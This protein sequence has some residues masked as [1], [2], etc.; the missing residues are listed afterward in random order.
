MIDVNAPDGMF[1]AAVEAIKAINL[2]DNYIFRAEYLNRPKHNVL[3]YQRIPHNTV[4]VYDIEKGDGT[5][6]Y[7]PV[8]RVQ[9]VADMYGFETVPT[10]WMGNYEDITQELIDSLLQT[11]AYLGKTLIEGIVIKCYGMFDSNDNVLMCK[12][13]RPEFKEMNG[14]KAGKPQV[15]VVDKIGG[16]LNNTMRWLKSVQ[17]LRDDGVLIGDASDIGLLMKELNSDFDEHE[18]MVK[19]LLY[20]EF[21]KKI[22]CVANAGFA[23]WYK[24]RL[25]EEAVGTQ[26]KIKHEF[27]VTHVCE[28][29]NYLSCGPHDDHGEPYICI[30][31]TDKALA[32]EIARKLNN[33][34]EA[35]VVGHMG[36]IYC[37]GI[38]SVEN[39]TTMSKGGYKNES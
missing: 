7:L 22:L 10:L 8:E 28:A 36:V 38:L 1:V 30:P 13:V 14:G 11:Q 29:D 26:N 16:M 19:G 23:V 31:L 17:H 5:N 12:Y 6:D 35:F 2:P 25:M 27:Y 20:A 21:R 24:Q 39:V 37:E 15:A 34:E 4:I 32:T 3:E 18:D 9:E 33:G